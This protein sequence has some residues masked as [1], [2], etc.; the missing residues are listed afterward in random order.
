MPGEAGYD[1]A[2]VPYNAVYAQRRPA[3]VARCANP[4]DVQACVETA[5][6]SR[7]PVAAR[8]GGHSYGGYS[9]PEQGLVVDLGPMAGVEVRP[10][11]TAVVQAGARL[12]DV[13]AALAAQNRALPAGSCPS[14]GIA[15]LTLGG[16]QGVLTRFLGLTCDTLRAADVVL[17]DS[18]LVTATEGDD[19]DLFWALRG[20]GGGNLGVVT[21]FTFETA[22]APDVT[23]LAL[24][25]P[26]GSVPAVLGAWVEWVGAAPHELWSNCVV[27]AGSPPSCRVGGCFVGPPG[28]LA[29]L[30]DELVTRVGTAPTQR[31]VSQRGYLDAMRYFA[32]C[33]TKPVEQCRQAAPSTFVGSSRMLRAGGRLDPGAVAATVDGRTGIDLLFDSLGGAVA[34]V[35]ADATAFPHRDAAAAVQVYASGADPA[36]VAEVQS[37]LAGVVGAGAYVNYIDPGQQDWATA[38]YGANLP[39]LRAAAARYDPDRVFDFPQGL[40]RA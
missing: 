17:P 35:A 28:A 36:P 40:A 27:S 14:V 18:T 31:T 19:G 5:R 34:E 30:V 8:G 3:A 4:A 22:P 11:G 39:R 2:R 32:G 7:T 25:F 20:G 1:A 24:R 26:A 37:A 29:P 6:R 33:S 9:T 23:V 38:Y 10:D 15:G 16:G 13:Y 12:I 21:A